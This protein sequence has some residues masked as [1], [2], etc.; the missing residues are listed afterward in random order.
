L[1]NSGVLYPAIM[2]SVSKNTLKGI[3]D[4]D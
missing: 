2:F 1:W 4:I 3:L